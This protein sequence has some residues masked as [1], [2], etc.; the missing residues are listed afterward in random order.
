MK[1]IAKDIVGWLCIVGMAYFLLIVA[2]IAE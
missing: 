1:N 2:A